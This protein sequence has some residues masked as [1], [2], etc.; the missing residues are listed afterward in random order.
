M[1]IGRLGGHSVP[2]LNQLDSDPKSVASATGAGEQVGGIGHRLV[3]WVSQKVQTLS[4]N[5]R[6]VADRFAHDIEARFAGS[7]KDNLRA[8]V[9]RSPRKA[10]ESI[11]LKSFK[12]G[13]DPT[14]VNVGAGI[15]PTYAN[16][17]AAIDPTYV[18][19]GARESLGFENATYSQETS[20]QHGQ[21]AFD[22][23]AGARESFGFENS[24][25]GDTST[26]QYG[27][28]ATELSERAPAALPIDTSFHARVDA[29][30]PPALKEA[31]N[32]VKQV[33]DQ[34]GAPGGQALAESGIFVNK[35]VIGQLTPELLE[36]FE[37]K[38]KEAKAA[39]RAQVAAGFEVSP[40][41]VRFDKFNSD[42]SDSPVHAV[43]QHAVFTSAPKL[44]NKVKWEFDRVLSA[45][46][47]GAKVK[48]IALG[49]AHRIL[50]ETLK[51]S[52]DAGRS[53]SPLH[54]VLAKSSLANASDKQLVRVKAGYDDALTE[55][56]FNYS[57]NR[58]L[59]QP[60]DPAAFKAEAIKVAHAVIEK[61]TF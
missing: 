53:D 31:I 9:S 5:T 38:L 61:Y 58:G 19:V 33:I 52:Y 51:E 54:P 20:F 59:D 56:A 35:E 60:L 11:E 48:D 22:A 27:Q 21:N 23:R 16:V 47:S 28:L 44:A 45:G 17:G 39:T 26:V 29:N 30:S 36:T 46:V 41:E 37:E 57:Y 50:A 1:P 32:F 55:A 12:K 13:I 24:T 49:V 42:N 18:N 8:L 43:L 7:A 14:Y 4:D 2:D 34:H 3:Q 40:S 15:D 10:P 25:Y 6:A